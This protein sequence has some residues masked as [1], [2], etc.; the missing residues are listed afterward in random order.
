MGL[1]NWASRYLQ[2]PGSGS[3]GLFGLCSTK[4]GPHFVFSRRDSAVLATPEAPLLVNSLPLQP[5]RLGVSYYSFSL[6][7]RLVKAET[8]WLAEQ[9]GICL[10]DGW[11]EGLVD[12]LID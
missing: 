5:C 4:T 2:H 1:P 12:G 11:M 10:T 6:S 3:V 9:L 7:L 8:V